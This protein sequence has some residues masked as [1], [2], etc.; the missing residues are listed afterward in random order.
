MVA[1]ASDDIETG[2]RP[3]GG[4]RGTPGRGRP[5]R[6][7]RV[8][9]RPP[10]SGGVGSA[11]RREGAGRRLREIEAR[12]RALI[13]HLPAITYV[14]ALGPNGG[15]ATLFVS[16][17]V[18]SILGYPPEAFVTN[19]RLRIERVHP[20]DRQRVLAED[21]RTNASG[22][23]LDIEY[24][25]I[26]RDG[27]VVWVRD[28]AVLV[29]DAA[30]G[31]R[32]WQGV[33]IDITA[34]KVAEEA[35]RES[36]V[37]YRDVV[38]SQ[39]EL[40]CRYRPDTTLTFVNEAYCRS[41]RRAR[42]ELIGTPFLDHVPEPARDAIRRQVASLVAQPRQVTYEHEVVRPDGSAGWQQWVDQPI[43][44]PDGEVVEVQGI[45]RDVTERRRAEAVLRQRE[46]RF[47]A[48]IQNA[49]DVITVLDP[50]GIVRYESPGIER[51][52][53]YGSDELVGRDARSLVHPDDAA[54]VWELVAATCRRPGA[55]VPI[56]FRFRHKDGSW[57][58]LEA[59]AT[60]LL[61][62]PS[63][64]G[65]VVNSRDVTERRGLEARLEHQAFHDALTGLPNRS[66]FLIRLAAA[67][68]D[69]AA[70][71]GSVAVLFLD[72]N[73][74]KVIN[75]GMGHDAG[76]RLLVA[77]GHR[78]RGALRAGETVGRL[79]GDE[80]TVLLGRV[81]DAAEAVAAA[82]RIAAALRTPVLLD[83]RELHVG[84]TLGVA[85]G[86]PGRTLPGDLLRDADT[87]LYRA[88][89]DQTSVALFDPSMKAAA[90]ARLELE[91]DL[92]RA[93]ER[94]ELELAYQPVVALATG[95][96]SA[97]EALV[98]WRHPTRGSIP[99][100]DFI[101]LAEETGLIAP[102]G[103]WVLEE[104]C[105]RA[106]AWSGGGRRRG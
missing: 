2:V 99:P 66:L 61:D 23:P 72:L 50:G 1:I 5:V 58:W 73:H 81:D 43:V 20:D 9:R 59:I 65:I 52:L 34:R 13:E 27:R 4:R 77:V 98:R 67:L 93:I 57:R 70:G 7:A 76:D 40:V 68:R 90:W 21:A 26:A 15:S 54:R 44:G 96:V 42:E 41:F 33:Q 101:G 106:R 94:R 83:G 29:E 14:D 46:A 86:V 55:N 6:V 89:A 92:R 10:R 104:A 62:D 32:S 64:G 47:R 3:G 74:F 38:E 82:E 25:M 60:N 69:G 105:R 88:K 75:D 18:E 11:P 95:R 16:P 53:G 8:R 56:E 17:Q 24:R 78:L 102:L 84:G 19:P 30:A 79:G 97:V 51:V 28:V 12:Y 80:F 39:S 31:I 49:S 63:V 36:E 35:L 91:H 103:R 37:R 71:G 45:G 100:A 85:L 22:E 87:A 48:L